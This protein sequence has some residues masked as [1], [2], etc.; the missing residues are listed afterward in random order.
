MPSADV[1]N[2]A[3]RGTS[4]SRWLMMIP[5]DSN[6]TLPRWPVDIGLEVD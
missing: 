3:N 6:W 2:G 4:T 5:W 1:S